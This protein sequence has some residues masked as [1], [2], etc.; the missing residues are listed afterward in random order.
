M[1]VASLRG[2]RLRSGS[3]EESQRH[4]STD[5]AWACWTPS[6]D[7]TK[8]SLS[9]FRALRATPASPT[10]PASGPSPTTTDQVSATWRGIR[11]RWGC[12]QIDRRTG[13]DRRHITRRSTLRTPDRTT[14]SP[15]IDHSGCRDRTGI[16]AGAA[17]YESH[18]VPSSRFI[19][20]STSANFAV[21]IANTGR[22][23]AQRSSQ[24]PHLSRIGTP[25]RTLNRY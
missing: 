16:C 17:V 4:G 5:G 22:R 7:R 21:T 23:S 24:L 19:R 20:T 2:E 15:A 10:P 3:P 9:N 18:F 25:V 1:S 8:P 14:R 6:A 13:P 12:E 11:A